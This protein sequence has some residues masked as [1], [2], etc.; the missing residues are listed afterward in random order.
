MYSKVYWITC[1]PGKSAALLDHYDTE[2][3]KAVQESAYH[4][5]HQMIEVE[6]GKWLLISN[7]KSAQAAQDALPLVQ[8]LVAPMTEKFGMNLE[9]IGEGETQRTI[10]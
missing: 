1:D 6:Q 2:T 3:T 8:A 9:V 10:S 7:Y 4:V 5:G